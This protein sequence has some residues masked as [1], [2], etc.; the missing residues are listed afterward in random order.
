MTRALPLPARAEPAPATLLAARWRLDA[1]LP[2]TAAAATEE[3]RAWDTAQGR[4]VTV[5]RVRQEA[6]GDPSV[7]SA[8][9]RLAAGRDVTRHPNLV[10]RLAIGGPADTPFVVSE[11]VEGELLE[12]RLRRVGPLSP[13]EVAAIVTGVAA[14]LTALHGAGLV[15]RDVSPATILLGAD[16]RI[17]LADPGIGW[18]TGRHHQDEAGWIDPAPSAD[19]ALRYRAPEVLGGNASTAAADAWSLAAVAYA[20][21]TGRPPVVIGAAPAV[22]LAPEP[23]IRPSLLRPGLDPAVDRLLLAALGPAEER[24]APYSFAVRLVAALRASGDPGIDGDAA[25]SRGAAARRRLS[26][27]RGALLALV[28]GGLVVGAVAAGAVALDDAIASVRSQPQHAVEPG[29][30]AGLELL[31]PRFD[32]ASVPAPQVDPAPAPAV[33]AA[34]TETTTRPVTSDR[35][36]PS[37]RLVTHVGRTRPAG[38]AEHEDHAEAD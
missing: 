21:L 22:G 31:A 28:A 17:R 23:P 8:V 37:T 11:L 36:A 33:R 35:R 13:R 3:W 10:E 38:G 15:H 12:A 18:G 29:P 1:R 5:R 19:P 24:P 30:L 4:R 32:D 25:G 20:A 27:A 34:D 16:G 7:I 6:L 2:G 14:G 9:H 26:R